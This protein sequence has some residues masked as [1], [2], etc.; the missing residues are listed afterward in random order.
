MDRE[1]SRRVSRAMGQRSGRDLRAG[2]TTWDGGA[3]DRLASPAGLPASGGHRGFRSRVH[4]HPA[5][6]AKEHGRARSL[7]AKGSRT[8][9]APAVSDFFARAPKT[10]IVNGL[11]EILPIS[12]RFA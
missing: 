8:F 10:A 1:A 3:C 7:T 12:R 9:L 5:A 6:G 11:G 2:H 4:G